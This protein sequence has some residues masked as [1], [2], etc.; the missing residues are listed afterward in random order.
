MV[1]SKVGRLLIPR[2]GAAR[3]DQGFIDARPFDPVFDYS[4]DG[5]MRSFES[6]VE[7]LG[8]DRIARALRRFSHR[9][10]VAAGGSS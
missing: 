8:V 3:D 7:R 10:A 4:Y 2:D 1:S 6:S 9:R 5:V